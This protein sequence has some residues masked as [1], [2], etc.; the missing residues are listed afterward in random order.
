[1]PTL[2]SLAPVFSELGARGSM[3]SVTM[4]STACAVPNAAASAS[5]MLEY[6]KLQTRFMGRRPPGSTPERPLVADVGGVIGA[7]DVG[8]AVQ[9][10]AR[11]R[12]RASAGAGEVREVTAVAGRLMALLAQHGLAHLEQV[13]RGRA[14]RV[15]AVGAVF[16]DRRG[17]GGGGAARRR[18]AGRPA[19]LHVA[20]VA[21]V[22]D[23]VAQHHDAPDRAVRVVAVGAGDQSFADRMARGAVD[24]DALH[25]V[26]GEAHFGLSELVAHAVGLGVQLVAGRAGDVVALVRAARPVHALASLVAGLADLVFLSR[27]H[28]AEALR[29]GAAALQVLGRVAVAGRATYDPRRRAAVGLGAVLAAPDERRVGVAGRADLAVLDIVRRLRERRCRKK[30]HRARNENCSEQPCRGRRYRVVFIHFATPPLEPAFARPG[31]GGRT[32][33]PGVCVPEEP[34]DIGPRSYI[35]LKIHEGLGAW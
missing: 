8:M 30:Q 11:E 15:V 1:M 19:F 28:L 4:G 10:A 7:V 25:L 21:G 12:V 34:D 18:A 16:R 17:G 5:V 26:A 27:G 31:C 14:V 2:A 35:G 20:A 32:N 22:V 13:R 33:S 29:H 23:G 3:F 9:A 24:L 6:L